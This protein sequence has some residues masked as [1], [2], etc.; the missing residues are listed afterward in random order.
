MCVYHLLTSFS[1]HTHTCMQKMH[2]NI[3]SVQIHVVSV[4]MDNTTGINI[5][6]F[7]FINV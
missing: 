1:V 2:V 7:I 3:F 5:I 6:I 4:I